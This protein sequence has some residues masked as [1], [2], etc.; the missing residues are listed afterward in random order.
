MLK[1]YWKTLISLIRGLIY[2]KQLCFIGTNVKLGKNVRISYLVS[3]EDNC[4]IGNNTFIGYCCIL[5][6]NVKIGNDCSFG[7]LT[8]IEKNVIIKN[9]VSFHAQC[10][11]TEGTYV[12]DNVFVA[13]MF[14]GTNTKI[15]DH[16]RNLNPPIEGPIIRRAVRIASNVKL[17]PGV[18]IGENALIGIG[19]VV[20]KDVPPREIWF[21]NPARKFGNVKE[22]EIL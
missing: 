14:M 4:Q 8:V 16:G 15:I 20:T 10:H 17:L 21:G 5:R 9:R 13:P 7:H 18:E 19:S 6:P 1:Y 3:I 12:E 22:D 2:G 11:I